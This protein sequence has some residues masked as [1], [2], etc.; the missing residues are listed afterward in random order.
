MTTSDRDT[1]HVVVIG[2]GITGL[3]AAAEVAQQH[4]HL[5]VTVLEREDQSPVS[6]D[7][8][9]PLIGES[10]FQ[11]MQVPARKIHVCGPLRRVQCG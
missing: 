6:V 11:W 4:P 3:A 10:P 1:H 5:S 8:D 7:A 2:A 9:A